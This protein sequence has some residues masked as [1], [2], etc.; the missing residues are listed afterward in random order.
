VRRPGLILV[1]QTIGDGVP[2]SFMK[3]PNTAIGHSAEVR[4]HGMRRLVANPMFAAV[5]GKALYEADEL[6]SLDAI[7]AWTLVTDLAP[8]LPDPESAADWRDYVE[9]RQFRGSLPMGPALITIDEL[10]SPGELTATVSVNDVEAWS[11]IICPP[12]DECAAR[13]SALSASYAFSP[14]DVVAFATAIDS[15]SS[16]RVLLEAGDTFSA[17]A[18]GVMELGFRMRG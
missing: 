1:S 9:A 16:P 11:G 15:V 3:S 7:S 6:A 2:T 10:G 13:L 8:E 18:G 12:V 4:A 14:G 5:L 17:D